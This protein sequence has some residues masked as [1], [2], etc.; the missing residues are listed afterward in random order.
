MK[1]LV[2]GYDGSCGTCSRMAVEIAEEVGEALEVMP[3]MAPDMRQWRDEV[4]GESPPWR[5]TLV[6]V[7]DRGQVRAWSGRKVAFVLPRLIGFRR[8]FKILRILGD[9][10]HQRVPGQDSGQLSRAS[11]VR[12]GLGVVAGVSILGGAKLPAAA[13]AGQA[14]GDGI[15]ELIDDGAVSPSQGLSE[16]VHDQV[17]PT[18]NAMLEVVPKQ[19]RS[20]I[21]EG[22]RSISSEPSAWSE[23]I[24]G[25][26]YRDDGA[27]THVTALALP[28]GVL[29]VYRTSPNEGIAK[30][31]SRAV[32][33]SVKG[34][35]DEPEV[36]LLGAAENG[37]AYHNMGGPIGAN[38]ECA[39]DSRCNQ[40][41]WACLCSQNA[42]GCMASRCLRCALQCVNP[43]R[44]VACVV[45]RCA[46]AAQ[47]CCQSWSCYYATPNC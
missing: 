43:V 30:S 8:S 4:Y 22:L 36:H 26:R 20:Q 17:Q 24:F 34:T 37:V 25:G 15:G 33:W 39:G 9:L 7:D 5:P 46:S 12:A 40:P 23:D 6:Q 14:H 32:F 19:T 2:L 44:C 21:E 31:E 42:Y 47:A 11:F 1:R 3:L 45:V 35:G 38:S 29:A 28:S 18:L 13:A 16:L 41:C 27:V 10:V